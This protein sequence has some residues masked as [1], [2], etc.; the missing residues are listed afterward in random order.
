MT[1]TKEAPAPTTLDQMIWGRQ[2]AQQPGEDFHAGA[3]RVGHGV[4]QD[5]ADAAAYADLI[6]NKL[7]IPG[8]RILAG[9]GSSH[10]NLLN[11]FVQDSRPYDDNTTDGVLHLAKK[12]A[13]VTKVGGGNG[14]NLDPIP[15]KRTYTGPIGRAYLTIDPSHDDYV[16]VRDGTYMDLVVGQ[17]VTKPYQHLAFVERDSVLTTDARIDMLDSV[18]GI[19]GA[20]GQMVQALLR[21]EDVLVDISALRPEGAPVAGSGGTSSGSSSFSVEILENFAHW[22]ALGAAEYAGPVATLRHVFAPTLRVIR[23]GGCLTPDTLVHT[24]E[25]TY[26]LR[27]LA[28]DQELVAKDLGLLVATD[29][30]PRLAVSSWNNGVTDTLEITLTNGQ[31]LRGTPNHKVKIQLA[32]GRRE[33]KALAD[34]SKGDWV[35]QAMGQH[36]GQRVHLRPVPPQHHNSKPITTPEELDADLAYVLGYLWGDGFITKDGSHRFGF[37]VA[38]DAHI[39]PH[40]EEY[41]ARAFGLTFA[42]ERRPNNNSYILVTKSAAFCAWLRENGLE[43]PYAADLDVPLTIRRSQHLDAFVGG[44]FEADGTTSEGKPRLHGI[45]E[46]FMRDMQIML[47]GLGI[48]STLRPDAGSD[49]WGDT[50]VW[51]LRV[52]SKKGLE[53]YLAQ[54]PIISGSRF[55]MLD[56]DACDETRE[57]SWPIPH[58]EPLVEMLLVGTNAGVKG[59]PSIDTQL[60][61]TLFRYQRGDRKLTAYAAERFEIPGDWFDVH[62]W[63]VKSVKEGGKSLTLDLSVEGNNT[64]LAGGIVTHNTRR[65]AGMATLSATHPDL[66]DFITAKDLARE[67]AEGDI[68]TFNISVL[69]SNAFMHEATTR[70]DSRERA[71]LDQ[72][73]DH[74][75]QTGEPGIIF[76]DVINQHFALAKIDGPIKATNP[77]VTGDTLV[78][79]S[80]GPRTMRELAEAGQDVTVWAMDPKTRDM[81]LRVMRQPRK[82]RENHPILAITFDSGLT[83]RCTPDH[84]LFTLAGEKIQAKDLQPGNSI[85]AYG[86]DAALHARM[87]ASEARISAPLINHKVVS[88]EDAG[89]EDVYNGTVD[90]HHTYLIPDADLSGGIVSANCGEIPLA[91]GEPCDLGAINLAAHLKGKKIDRAKLQDT[92]RTAV[93]FLDDVLTAEVAPLPEIRDAIQD[94]RR[95]GLGLMG[96]ADMLIRMGLRYD[97][98]EG[99]AAVQEAVSIIRDVALEE[100][101][102]LAVE[103]GIPAGVAR[104][105]LERRNIAVFT[106]APTGTTSM[107]AGVSGGVEPVFAATYARKIG[108]QYVKVVHPILESLLTELDPAE[109]V[110]AGGSSRFIAANEDGIL[111]WN[112]DALVDALNEHHGSLQPLLEHLPSDERLTAYVI[113]HDIAF[114]DHVLM[115]ATIQRAFDWTSDAAWWN[116]DEGGMTLAGNSLS[117]TINMPNSATIADVLEA[118]KLAWSEGCKGITVYRD[119]S[120]D[121]QVLTTSGKTEKKPA[122]AAPAPT[123]N[124]R[125]VAP[126]VDAQVDSAPAPLAVYQ[127]RSRMRGVT[128]KVR[129]SDGDGNQRG[130]F[131]TVNSNGHNDPREVFIISGKGGDEANGDS[132][133][134]GRVVS[135]ALQ[136]SVPPEALIKTLRGI[137]GGMFGTYQGRIVTSKADLIAVALETANQDTESAAAPAPTVKADAPKPGTPGKGCPKCGAPLYR[138][139]GCETCTNGDCG[140][141]RCGT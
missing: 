109:H 46:R 29:E 19:W 92:T 133:A 141:S 40:L 10:G 60:R 101:H 123:S 106:V 34:L 79:T 12:L 125:P 82:T 28:G 120:R 89:R 37:A 4:A 65:G 127:R 100:S 5:P 41:F 87:P 57:S 126:S 93:R 21:G 23:Q 119:G 121:M 78:L 55:E 8:G 118:Y 83:L 88:V 69:A 42:V 137:S 113:A 122:A 116:G 48:P 114:P 135:I 74:A 51:T 66:L 13:L 115:Q 71:I 94:K 138:T 33:W 15:G 64:Y 134:L 67:Q 31:R 54:V 91:P 9:A 108:T 22:A 27:E 58:A 47:A 84:N 43:K 105:G 38:D 107:L 98:N 140:W 14:V 131:I 110:N 30:G 97:S 124:G 130:F 59:R 35:I 45:S 50:T 61:K 85:L 11:C 70:P 36:Q 99:R 111:S 81:H 1:K 139:E 20:A 132:E 18:E 103:R 25:G 6:I 77:C 24:A 62:H 32:N 96:L 53:R 17:Y 104:A 63:Q 3:L 44:L 76:D 56:L 117:K 7:F 75:W 102:R 2:Y 80:S 112:H 26:R 72:I 95:I 129:L 49:R 136:Y 52:L 39:G 90:E 16:K 68:S 128:D 86:E 73:A